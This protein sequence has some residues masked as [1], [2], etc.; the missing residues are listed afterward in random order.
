MLRNIISS[1]VVASASIFSANALTVNNTVAGS[2]AENISSPEN[3]TTLTVSGR[4]NAADLFYISSSM[5]SL[6]SL[7][8]RAVTIEAYRGVKLQG[9]STYPAA[10]IPQASFS[11]SKLQSVSLPIMTD[12]SI[13]EG[14][15][16]GSSLRSVT[17]NANVVSV[18]AGAFTG[19]PELTSAV[20]SSPELGTGAFAGCPKLATVTITNPIHLG[21]RSFS[22]CDALISV[23]GSDNVVA[24]GERAFADCITLSDFAFGSSL[25]EIGDEAF[26]ASALTAI[27][28]AG[29]RQLQSVGDWAFAK[30]PALTSVNMGSVRTIGE[31]IV[32]DCPAL[33]DMRASAAATAVPAYAY[34][35]DV[36]MDTTHMLPPMTEQIG[37]YALAGMTQ[38]ET[39][40]LPES[41]EYIGS[42]AMKDMSGLKSLTVSTSDVPSLGENVW[43]GVNQPQAILYVPI[44][45]KYSYEGADQWREFT[46]VEGT[47]GVDD[48]LVPETVSGL[49]GRFVGDELQVSIDGV[50][51]ESLALYDTAGMMLASL[52]P[53]SDMVSIDTEGMSTRIFIITATLTD[54]RTATLKLAK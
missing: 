14:A 48:A 28:L 8:L 9:L 45:A 47:T 41:V 52:Q 33:T 50:D 35:G 34:V 43:D 26:T 20:I 7:D 54:G 13:G 38:V 1:I 12:L 16:A 3:V 53:M 5:P 4:V 36:K 31:G 29:C 19:C 40:T 21:E 27:D 51:I 10:T 23:N 6:V 18:G 22:G 44:G 39:L 46:I 11:G 2:L 30:M 17:L 32:F 25:T 24:V 15:F 49:R 37:D 42:Y